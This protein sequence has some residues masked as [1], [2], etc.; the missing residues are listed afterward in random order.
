[1]AAASQA[2]TT[3]QRT[4]PA[5]VCLYGP[6]GIGT[7]S[8]AVAVAHAVADSFPDGQI[9]LAL[10]S[11][12]RAETSADDLLAHVLR[13]LGGP[14]IPEDTG[15]RTALLRTLTADRRLLILADDA[16]HAA[17][18]RA[19][20]P[21]ASGCAVLVTSIRPLLGLDQ[22]QHIAV[23]PLAAADAVSL[24]AASAGRTLAADADRQAIL[25][26]CAGLPL[27]LRIVG[28]RL[29]VRPASEVAVAARALAS[30]D[31]RLDYLVAGDLA[32]RRGLA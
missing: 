15:R 5:V 32:V 23:P 26:S 30:D 4:A 1:L 6:P 31:H 19:I 25:D 13:S 8:L 9:H 2:L 12:D 22:V 29:S 24:L 10:R 28:S 3:P 21:A 18:I 27:A 20:L 17:Q 14:E 11:P 16:G 7:T